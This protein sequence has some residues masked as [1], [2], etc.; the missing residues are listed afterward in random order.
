MID[1]YGV[2]G[3]KKRSYYEWSALKFKILKS[4]MIKKNSPQLSKC[5]YL[6]RKIWKDTRIDIQTLPRPHLFLCIPLIPSGPNIRITWRSGRR[7]R[8]STDH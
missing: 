8:R 7:N 1:N 6:K 2:K 5:N 4:K 3:M